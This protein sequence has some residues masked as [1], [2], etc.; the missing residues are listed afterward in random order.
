[1]DVAARVNRLLVSSATLS[2]GKE[3]T[4]VA[5]RLGKRTRRA[6][7]TLVGPGYSALRVLKVHLGL[8]GGSIQLPNRMQPGRWTLA[9]VSYANLREHGHHVSGAAEM[10]LAIFTVHAAPRH[11]RPKPH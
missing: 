10:R 4:V 5:A 11:R 9:I 7:V 8:A 6:I 1:V 3:I 2:P